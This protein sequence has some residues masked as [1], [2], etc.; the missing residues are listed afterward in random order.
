MKCAGVNKATVMIGDRPFRELDARSWDA[1]ARIADMDRDGVA[2]QVLS[3]MPELLSYWLD[4][5]EA[6]P[7]LERCNH[8]IAEL[9]SRHPDRFRGL[10]AVPLQDPAQAIEM[11][12]RIRR[13]FG[14]SGIEIGSNV[15]GRMLGDPAHDPFWAAVA[16][17]GLAVFVHALHPL[18]GKAA[19]SSPLF[20][21]FA[22]FPVD[23]GMAAASLLMAGV[24]D[25]HPNLRIGFSHGGGTLLSMLGRL[26]IGWSKTGGFGGQAISAPSSAASRFY[27]DTNVY[28]PRL[29]RHMTSTMAPGRIFA[30]TD[31][32]YEI[33][34]TDLREYIRSAGL[35]DAVERS[36]MSG[37]AASFLRDYEPA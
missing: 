28:D 24:L 21:V 32:P 34:Q 12:P 1:E 6:A 18:A 5:V 14:L 22:L 11:L 3:P 36:V 26:D 4:A 17:E 37:A 10:G 33:M 27:Y 29:L 35:G 23:V 16:D 13:E 9:A 20:N 7:I 25:R 2:V 30:G 15:A 31:Y 8:Q 19:G